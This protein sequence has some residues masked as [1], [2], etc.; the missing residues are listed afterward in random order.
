MLERKTSESYRK[1]NHS[2]QMLR[3]MGAAK[4]KMRKPRKSQV[5]NA[6]ALLPLLLRRNSWSSLSLF[7]DTHTRALSLSQCIFPSFFILF[8]GF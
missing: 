7:T 6:Q 3:R 1:G 5:E 2:F 4:R 8:D